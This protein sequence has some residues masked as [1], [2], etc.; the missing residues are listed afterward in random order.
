V[1]VEL[2]RYLL[3]AM[4]VRHQGDYALRPAI[5]ASDAAE[6]ITRAAQFL[7][8]AERLIGPLLPPEGDRGDA[9]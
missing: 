3:E 5:S 2:H 6:Q 1:P 9:P 7:A 8:A 4:A